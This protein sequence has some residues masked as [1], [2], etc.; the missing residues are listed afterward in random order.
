MTNDVYGVV[1]V[2][3]REVFKVLYS[4][5]IYLGTAQNN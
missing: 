3:G 2:I 4:L 5:G 1:F